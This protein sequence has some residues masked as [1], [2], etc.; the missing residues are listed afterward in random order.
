MLCCLNVLVLH[1]AI[2]LELYK[3]AFDVSFPI[4]TIKLGKK[5]IKREPWMTTGLINSSK[6]RNK[7]F[8]K[9]SQTPSENNICHY[10]NY[11][12][13]FN[14]LKR[15][16]KISYYRTA[17]E[18]NRHNMKQMW[19]ILNQAVNKKSKTTNFPKSF[20]INN[21]PITDESRIAIAFNQF[22]STIG[23]NISNNIPPTTKRYDQYLLQHN[24]HS[25]FLDPVH[26]IDVLNVTRK[27]K[28][29][30]S[31]GL[32]EI[33][34]K[35][36]MKSIDT[37]LIPITHIINQSFKLG[38]FPDSLK[39]AKVV[40]IF[41]ASDPTLLNN[42]RPISLLSPFSKLLERLMYNKLVKYL[43]KHDIL[44]QHQYGFRSKH[45]TIHP[46]IHFLN[47][48]GQANN[49]TPNELTLA[50]FCD[51]SKAFDSISQKILLHK[52]N[53]YGIRGVANG[54]LESYLTH[55]TQYVSINCKDSP[56]LPVSCGVPQGSILG[57]LLFLIYM[58]DIPRSTDANILSFA[59]DTTVFIS[60]PDPKIL[61]EKSNK[62]LNDIFDWFCANKLSLNANKTKFMVVHP[63]HKQYNLNNLNLYI[64][65][66]K[67]TRVGVTENE[68]S[69]KFLGIN[70]DEILSWKDHIRC[71]NS[72]ISRSLFVIKQVKTFLPR[73]S[74][75]TLYFTMI[76]PYL[77]YGI[78]AW[79]NAKSNLLRKTSIMQKRALRTINNKNFNCHTD[80][81][82]KR[83]GILKLS[84][85]YQQQVLLFMYDH[86]NGNLPKSFV[87][88]FV[89][90]KDIRAVYETRQAN[91]FHVPRSKSTFVDK[92]PLVVFPSIWNNM[93]KTV[94]GNNTRAQFKCKIK[95]F[96]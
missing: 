54:W 96:S 15:K 83:C 6:K 13:L 48:C 9:K 7:L 74:M 89:H 14:K 43:D 88:M 84:D 10:K 61:F 52:L 5:S 3:T 26:P 44:Y 62:C 79:G 22:F 55:R 92:L 65:G 57:P 70:M 75:R 82:F 64:N 40:P 21:T 63:T 42:Y 69:C 50:T 72:K 39:C 37:I 2:F 66:N 49:K 32:D 29:K 58:N 45:S 11:V 73:E 12:T 85:L 17:I 24:A 35:L 33:S 76:H 81:L 1:L 34:T 71:V 30:T 18:D 78:L 90:N 38:V 41:K 8:A 77:S 80:P 20:N 94:D 56:L 51:L 67:L 95:K 68:Q 86:Q 31:S 16:A 60:D 53:T 4:K 46:I 93:L 28:P 23:Q 47:K 19:K 59:D 91:M 27:M 87:N 25:M 36:M